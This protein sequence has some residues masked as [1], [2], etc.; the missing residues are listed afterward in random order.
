MQKR[1]DVEAFQM[2]QYENMQCLRK[3]EKDANDLKTKTKTNEE[4]DDTNEGDTCTVIICNIRYA[5]TDPSVEDPPP[6][7]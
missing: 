7:R 3:S 1:S 5:R 2:Y 4:A 6:Q